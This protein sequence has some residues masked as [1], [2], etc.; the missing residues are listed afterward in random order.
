HNQTTFGIETT[1]MTSQGLAA[2]SLEGPAWEPDWPEFEP[3]AQPFALGP[4][5]YQSVE[6][7]EKALAMAPPQSV[8]NYITKIVGYLHAKD[9]PYYRALRWGAAWGDFEAGMLDFFKKREADE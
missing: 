5:P 6:E 4:K 1:M 2:G 8:I 7:L 9:E 3:D